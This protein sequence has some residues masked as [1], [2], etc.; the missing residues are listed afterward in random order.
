MKRLIL[1]SL[2]LLLV[3]AGAL[4][5]PAGRAEAHAVLSSSNP[6]NGAVLEQA[7]TMVEI[8]F[9]EPVAAEFVPVQVRDSAGARVDV[10]DGRVD[11]LDKSRLVANLKPV[12]QGLYTVTYRV[13]SL[14]GHPVQGTLAFSVGTAVTAPTGAPA[15]NGAVVSVPASLLHGLTQWLS[16]LLA[17]L[18]AFLLLVWV[19][20]GGVQR[21]PA[22]LRVVG[23]AL[24][25]LLLLS[26]LGELGVYAV[27]ASGE[28]FSAGLLA[29]AATGT[30]TG[31]LWLARSVLALLAGAVLVYARRFTAGWSRALALLPGAGLLLTLSLQSH[32]MATQESLPVVADYAH[33]LAAAPWVGGL[34]GFALVLPG[35]NAVDRGALLNPTIL[36]FTRVATVAVLLLAATGLYGA[37]LH[38]PNL[39]ALTTTTYGRSLVIKLALL[40]PL[41]ALGAYNMVRK[42]HTQFRWAVWG[43]LALMVA[44]VGA[45]GFL[46]SVPPAQAEILAKA[47]PFSEMAHLETMM[48]KLSITPAKLGMN[49][50][51]I[52]LHSHDGT[53]ITEASAGLRVRMPEH[54][55]GLQNL[56]AKETAPGVYLSEPLVFGMPGAWQVEVVVLTKGGQEVRHTFSVTVQ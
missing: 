23:T 26:G 6:H 19:P 40:V 53:P 1:T 44:I 32:A 42:G 35:L 56:D 10:G 29:Q 25:G 48:I 49:T 46:S 14:D 27:R 45:A 20:L 4:L 34:A 9:N 2:G 15:A 12:G 50:P 7:P 5:L 18:P 13:T 38:L 22:S 37:F 47:G 33:L 54:D 55:M 39:E 24:A 41:L 28:E 30:R 17:G 52:E 36:R 31:Q 43:E 8:R 3:L 11:P 21:L 16:L 51:T